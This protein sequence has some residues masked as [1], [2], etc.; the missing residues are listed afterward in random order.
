MMS[1]QLRKIV[2]A[3]KNS[4]PDLPKRTEV[5]VTKSEYITFHYYCNLSCTF[6]LM[7][8]N[9]SHELHPDG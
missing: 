4:S 2:P 9:T 8:T 7:K 6:I 5:D 1:K 3:G